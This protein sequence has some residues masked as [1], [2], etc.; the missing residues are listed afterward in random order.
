MTRL[1]CV[2]LAATGLIGLLGDGPASAQTPIRPATGPYVRP[3]V[4]PY[5]TPAFSPYLNLG[6]AGSP[7][8]N[9]FGLVQ[10]Q[11]QFNSSIQQLQ[12]QQ[13]DT[14]NLLTTGTAAQGIPVTGVQAGYMNFSHYY[15]N[16]PVGGSAIQRPVTTPTAVLPPA[17]M[18][19]LNA[20]TSQPR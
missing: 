7:A 12:T 17:N 19:P 3:Q 6:R 15:G 9:Y 5:N 14:T 8:I 13:L 10:P 20:I 1:T 4:N 18:R 11:Q 2:A 16:R